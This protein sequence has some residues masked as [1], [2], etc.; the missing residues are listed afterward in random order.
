MKK[1]VIAVV[2]SAMM[3][4]TAYAEVLPGPGETLV[5]KQFTTGFGGKGA[6][7]AVMAAIAGAEV[8]FVGKIGKDVFGD[9][10][11]ENFSKRNVNTKYIERDDEPSGVAHIWVDGTGENR[12]I[13]IPGANHTID[14]A[15]AISAINEIP[16]LGIVIGQCEIKQE[17]TLAAFKAAKA[18]GAITIL[19]PAPFE[20]LS[21]EL[22]SHCDWIIPNET[23][24]SAL[25]EIDANI[26]L[27]LGDKGVHHLSSNLKVAALKVTPIDTTGAGDSF[28]GAFAA[29]LHEGAEVAMKFGCVAAGLSV[30]KKGAQS[31]YPTYEEI[32]TLS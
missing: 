5:G 6:N 30:T 20:T 4:L 21:E 7:Q 18:R 22:I 16:E 11:L 24:Y 12:I 9:S 32:A 25:G 17:V 27:T 23:E 26:L 3:D 13:I 1:P 29:K 2:G 8:F 28:V 14:K 31:S 15:N 19:N 10:F